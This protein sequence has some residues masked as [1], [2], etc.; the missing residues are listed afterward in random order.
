MP[1]ILGWMLEVIASVWLLYSLA[2]EAL[3]VHAGDKG[4]AQAAGYALLVGLIPFLVLAA[5]GAMLLLVARKH[6]DERKTFEYEQQVLVMLTKEGRVSL[7]AIGEVVPLNTPQIRRL[8][9][10]M[11]EKRLFTGYI[12]L[13]MGQV[14]SSEVTEL[15]PGECPVCN[16]LT[17]AGEPH[18]AICTRCD[19]RIFLPVKGAKTP[20]PASPLV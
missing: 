4:I 6:E 20:P 14:V 16:S 2:V 7:S 9:I 8:L 10:G 1:K 12:N 17:S 15:S 13:K 5:V 18:M 3:A 11:G 19:A